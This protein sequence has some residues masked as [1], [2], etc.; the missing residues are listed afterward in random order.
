M[1]SATLLSCGYDIS[2][3]FKAEMKMSLQYGTILPMWLQLCLQ[4]L[5]RV[6]PL[7]TLWGSQMLHLLRH[8]AQPERYSLPWQPRSITG[9]AFLGQSCT[10]SSKARSSALS[11]QLEK[12]SAIANRLGQLYGAKVTVISLQGLKQ[13]IFQYA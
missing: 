12:N 13:S 4:L 9:L 10:C 8:Q 11:L 6:Q 7:R 1:I 3:T 2:F 5:C